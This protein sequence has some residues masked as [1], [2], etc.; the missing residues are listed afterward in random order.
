MEEIKEDFI[1]KLFFIYWWVWYN[2]RFRGGVIL[3][4]TGVV[5]MDY[6]KL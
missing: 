4:Y 3:I 1:D 2:N 5:G 6:R